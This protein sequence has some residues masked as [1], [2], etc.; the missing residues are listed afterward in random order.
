MYRA[1]PGEPAAMASLCVSALEIIQQPLELEEALRP[2]ALAA[3][4]TEIVRVPR[5]ASAYRFSARLER[6]LADGQ[7]AARW[8]PR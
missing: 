2:L 8:L 6:A 4:R 3:R 7:R 5:L 1:T